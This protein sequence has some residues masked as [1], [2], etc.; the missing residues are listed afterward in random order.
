MGM[1]WYPY[2]YYS[3]TAIISACIGTISC[4]S[5]VKTNK[6]LNL[7]RY[8]LIKKKGKRQKAVYHLVTSPQGGT[9]KDTL[10][11]AYDSPRWLVK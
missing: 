9:Q 11:F 5:K 6:V 10:A 1:S 4:A 3:L 2:V 7:Y 8:E